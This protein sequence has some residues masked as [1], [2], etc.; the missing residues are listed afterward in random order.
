MFIKQF[1]RILVIALVLLSLV[2]TFVCADVN[3]NPLPTKNT[4]G[5]DV[6]YA[7]ENSV[8]YTRT[9][10]REELLGLISECDNKMAHA[11]NMA[12]SARNLGYSE[13][14][15]V[16]CYARG[17]YFR[18]LALKEKYQAD[19]DAIPVDPYATQRAAY[20]VATQVWEYLKNCGYNDYVCAG[21]LGNMMAECGGHTLNLKWNVIGGG[22]YYG[23]CQWNKG[24]CGGVWG[25]SI[26]GQLQYLVNTMPREF[27]VYGRNYSGGFNYN[28]FCGMTNERSAAIAFAKC[29]ERCGSGSYTA[30]QNNATVALNYFS[31]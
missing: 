28:S 15:L 16:I 19:Y 27:N 10:N 26:S 17:D 30:R 13:Q 6:L 23:L 1:L 5:Y 14:S 24:Y 11:H 8:I 21:I 12:Q 3:E 2:T 31:H 29:Y 18:N 4:E 9:N 22:Y 7:E 25:A 20:P